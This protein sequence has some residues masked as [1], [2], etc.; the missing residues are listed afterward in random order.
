MS[1]FA[2][3]KKGEER[4]RWKKIDGSMWREKNS[5]TQQQALKKRKTVY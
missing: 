2:E 1:F 5:L 3:G 4:R